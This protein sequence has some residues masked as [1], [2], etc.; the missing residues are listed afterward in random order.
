[1]RHALLAFAAL[2]L[3]ACQP[4]APDGK[5]AEPPADAPAPPIPPE[6]PPPPE[7]P[8]EF[9]GDIDARGTEPFWALEIRKETLTLK[10]PAPDK[11]LAVRNPGAVNDGSQA[12]WS[13]VA[14]DGKAFIVTLVMEGPCSDGMSDLTYPYVAVVTYGALT[15][16][17]C[18]YKVAEKPKGA[19]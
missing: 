6:P 14:P 8:K 9:V 15:Y 16:R 5:R 2:M 10:R 18:A 11:E 19:N 12:V 1:M 7:E 4:Q 17:G 13:T 3:A